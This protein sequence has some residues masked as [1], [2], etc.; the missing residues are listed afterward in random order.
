MK[1]GGKRFPVPDRPEVK[2]AADSP[3]SMALALFSSTS[4]EAF[5]EHGQA[6]KKESCADTQMT[7][8]LR[9]MAIT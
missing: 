4:K 8:E 5:G 2:H 1:E 9:L 7:L 3:P 6:R